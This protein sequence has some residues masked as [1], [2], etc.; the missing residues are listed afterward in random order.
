MKNLVK[1]TFCLLVVLI[2]A[3]FTLAQ[4]KTA[5]GN[6]CGWSEGDGAAIHMRIG[7]AVTMFSIYN[8]EPEVKYIGFKNKY[9]HSLPVGSEIIINYVVKKKWGQSEKIVRSVTLTGKINKRT[10]SCDED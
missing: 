5:K 1:I 6:F 4:T 10:P 2:F 7:N 3:G 8:D 9:I